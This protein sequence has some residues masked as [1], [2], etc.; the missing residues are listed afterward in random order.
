MGGYD[1]VEAALKNMIPKIEKAWLRK[2][3][4]KK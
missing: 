2:Q 3:G 4:A 1:S